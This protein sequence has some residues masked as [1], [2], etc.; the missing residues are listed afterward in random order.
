MTI[1]GCN[2]LKALNGGIRSLT[3]LMAL[4]ASDCES[5]DEEA[6]NILVEIKGLLFL[7]MNGSQS[8]IQSWEEKGQS[9]PLIVSGIRVSIKIRF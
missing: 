7:E 4:R 3:S 1:K 9:Y 5:L 2:N 8:L 6:V